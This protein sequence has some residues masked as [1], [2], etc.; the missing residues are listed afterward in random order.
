[1]HRILLPLLLAL[2]TPS[3][4]AAQEPPEPTPSTAVRVPARPPAVLDAPI[5]TY[6]LAALEGGV[7]GG[8]VMEYGLDGDGVVT[9]VEV[10]R[11]PSP[12]LAAS[13][14]AALTDSFFEAPADGEVP[15]GLRRY[16]QY[17]HFEL[18]QEYRPPVNIDPDAPEPIMAD[19]L[20]QLPTL[21]SQASA[22]YP[23]EARAAGV[24]GSVDRKSVV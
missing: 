20:T 22:D 15:L 6:P 8:V 14:A 12:E 7:E 24:Q 5:P 19:E 11:A 13:A 17:T 1:M 23:V 21:T 2:L 16:Y 18:P 3:M 4:T 9:D 10:L